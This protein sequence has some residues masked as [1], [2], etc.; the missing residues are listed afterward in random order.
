LS[1]VYLVRHGQA[2]TRDS[3]DSLSDIG[4][5]QA[6]LLGAHLARERVHFSTA[7]AGGMT[8]QGQTAAAVAAA[9]RD[10]GLPFPDVETRR[11]WNEFDLDSVYRALAPRLC[12]DDADFKSG[13]DEMRAE[14]LAAAGD[15]SAAIHRRWTPC[16]VKVVE[17]WILGR[18]AY[19][20][21]SWPAFCGRIR[22]CSLG[23]NGT[24][25]NAIVFT[26]ATPAAIWAGKGLDLD[27]ERVL[28]IAGV[29]Y[30][31]SFTVLRVRAGQV[32]LFSLN[33]VPHLDDPALRTH[34]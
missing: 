6:R 34:R 10:A 22:A 28:R 16:D 26:S 12:Q 33:N 29:L 21:E 1:L 5:A 18:Y 17:S 11:E 31:S 14:L 24:E 2:G 15:P 25:S 20:G 23:V 13:Y 3:Y 32:R 9:Y 30:N 7:I 27:D 4:R 8:R 19:E